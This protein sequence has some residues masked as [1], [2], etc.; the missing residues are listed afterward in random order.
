MVC[1]GRPAVFSSRFLLLI[2]LQCTLWDF[3]RL[4]IAGPVPSR[5]DPSP[6]PGTRPATP[7]DRRGSL[8]TDLAHQ[9]SNDDSDIEAGSNKCHRC[10]SGHYRQSGVRGGIRPAMKARSYST[11]SQSRS[12]TRS[13]C[14]GFCQRCSVCRSGWTLRANCTATQDTVCMP[15]EEGEFWDPVRSRCKLVNP[16]IHEVVVQNSGTPYP[17][18]LNTAHADPTLPVQRAV[19]PGGRPPPGD[20][21]EN[22]ID[23]PAPSLTEEAKSEK[24]SAGYIASLFASAAA[25]ITVLVLIVVVLIY[26]VL[27]FK[28]WKYERSLSS[29]GRCLTWRSC[30]GNFCKKGSHTVAGD[31]DYSMTNNRNTE[32]QTPLQHDTETRVDSDLSKAREPNSQTLHAPGC[33]V[34]IDLADTGFQEDEHSLPAASTGEEHQP[35]GSFMTRNSLQS[36]E[37][38]KGLLEIWE[39]ADHPPFPPSDEKQEGETVITP[40]ER[41]LGREIPGKRHAGISATDVHRNQTKTTPSCLPLP[42]PLLCTTNIRT[43]V[44]DVHDPYMDDTPVTFNGTDI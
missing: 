44:A 14:G 3:S 24:W 40:Q 42:L 37:A 13:T 25:G 43:V 30:F 39:A 6:D 41:L 35:D 31:T 17:P 15:C 32:L 2:V 33:S 26:V 34:W 22:K 9:D 19:K 23:Q 12:R 7:E 8:R 36:R 5:S 20:S 11:D 29:R 10:R 1:T 18:T 38:R 21:Y 4:T 28:Q 27:R 16:L